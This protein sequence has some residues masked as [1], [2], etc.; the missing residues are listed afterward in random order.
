MFIVLLKFADN[1]AQAGEHMAGHR[2]WIQRGMKDGVFLLVGS[3]KPAGGG[4]VLAHGVTREA[5]ER[6]VNE[7]PF[8]EHRIV[9]VELIEIEPAMAD[10]RLKFLLAA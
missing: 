9:S 7:D 6:R 3:L 2:Q 8:V 5:L 1:K 10:E 4:V